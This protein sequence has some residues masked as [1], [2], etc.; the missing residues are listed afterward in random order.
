MADERTRTLK[1]TSDA[2]EVL[3]RRFQ[4]SKPARLKNLDEARANDS[5]SDFLRCA[6]PASRFSQCVVLQLA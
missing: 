5:W 6:S 3:H 4:E 1:P 2:L